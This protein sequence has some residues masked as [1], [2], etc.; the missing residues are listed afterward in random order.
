MAWVSGGVTGSQA[1]AAWEGGL[2]VWLGNS[3][4]N[5]PCLHQGEGVRGHA[6]RG[7]RRRGGGGRR[8]EGLGLSM[9]VMRIGGM[10][11]QG[12]AASVEQYSTQCEA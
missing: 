7:L 8:A 12:A 11:G 1:F 5:A 2:D 6:G 9:L 3:R 4:G 10:G